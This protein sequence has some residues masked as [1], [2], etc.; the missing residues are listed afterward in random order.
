M[1]VVEV[2]VGELV[3]GL[4]LGALLVVDAQVP[5]AE[6][7]VP[8]LLDER[9]LLAG[10][11]LVLAPR[12]AVVEHDGAVADALLRVVVSGPGEPDSHVPDLLLGTPR[13]VVRTSSPSML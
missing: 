12:V 2:P 4:R 6:L 9:V 11:R 3:V 1:H 10:R 8:V 5:A 7:R 13:V